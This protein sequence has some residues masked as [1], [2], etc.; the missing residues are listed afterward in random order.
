MENQ[1]EYSELVTADP[2]VN[3][4]FSTAPSSD[5]EQ[6]EIGRRIVIAILALVTWAVSVVFI[7]IIPALFLYPY[8]ASKGIP[9]SDG[10]QIV[11][12]AK[13]DQN[14]IFLQIIAIIPAHLLTILLAWLVVSQGRKY[15]FLKTLGWEKGG[16]RWW[17]YCFI[18]VAFVFV[19]ALVGSLYPEQDNDLIRMLRSSRSA[20]YIIAIV[21]TFS[22]PFIEEVIYRGVLF[23]GFKRAFGVPV[24]F[25][26]VTGLFALVHVPQYYPSYSTI[27]LLTLLSLTL[28]GLRVYSN[29][30][31][32]CVILHT[33]FNG[34]QSIM[35]IVEPY[36]GTPEPADPA[37]ILNHLLK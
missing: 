15:K 31:L 29:N 32:P 3:P 14:A 13:N 7:A 9:L 5:A 37:T 4:D 19:G 26:L 20:V 25:V 28:T 1:V 16:V 6:T 23:S 8:L 27:F 17:H 36:L 35:L 33:I 2:S 21:A 34:F 18:L 22:A 30:L 10:S 11:E 12:F 24:S